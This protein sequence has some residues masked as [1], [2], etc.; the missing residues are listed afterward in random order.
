VSAEPGREWRD[1][2]THLARGFAD[3][4]FAYRLTP[5]PGFL[6]I[7]ESVEALDGY[8]AKSIE[9]PTALVWT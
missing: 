2:A 6:D 1:V 4:T 9:Q 7:S 5:D 3:V 8:T